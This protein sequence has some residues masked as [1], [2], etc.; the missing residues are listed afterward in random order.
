KSD[1]MKFKNYLQLVLL[2]IVG[3][4]CGKKTEN[5]NSNFNLYKDYILNFSSGLVST[6][7][8][9]RV[10]LAFE[11]KDWKANQELDSDLFSISPKVKG[12]VVALSTNTVAF[13]PS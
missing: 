11:N 9:V 13:I 5:F 2:L 8:D 7:T 6:K 3:F 10:V 4:S 1:L 12:K